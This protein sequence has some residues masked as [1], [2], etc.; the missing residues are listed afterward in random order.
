MPLTYFF[1][2]TID[3]NFDMKHMRLFMHDFQLSLHNFNE[4]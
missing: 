2:F 3:E 1:T 4:I